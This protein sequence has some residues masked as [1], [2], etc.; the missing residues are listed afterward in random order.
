MSNRRTSRLS[1]PCFRLC[2][3]NY[4][5]RSGQFLQKRRLWI[6]MPRIAAESLRILHT[7]LRPS[8]LGP[9]LHLFQEILNPVLLLQPVPLAHMLRQHRLLALEHRRYIHI[10]IRLLR[11]SISVGTLHRVHEIQMRNRTKRRQR[12]L[13]RRSNNWAPRR[14][15]KHPAPACWSPRDRNDNQW[16]TRSTPVQAECAAST[17]TPAGATHRH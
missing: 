9:Q 7:R 5:S 10:E 4:D 14:R 2:T 12:H 11:P 16:G 1:L 17:R 13:R 8:R 6:W 15:S 3:G